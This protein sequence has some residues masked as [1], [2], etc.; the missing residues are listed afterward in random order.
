[1]EALR[2]LEDLIKSTNTANPTRKQ[3]M[4]LIEAADFTE[5]VKESLKKLVRGD[6]P[7]VFGSYGN[8]ALL[9]I[10]F[11]AVILAVICKCPNIYLKLVA[12]CGFSRIFPFEPVLQG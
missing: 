8:G 10:L 1:M 9:G 2:K 7:Q 12:P 11:V 3:A 6:V 5:E 4:E